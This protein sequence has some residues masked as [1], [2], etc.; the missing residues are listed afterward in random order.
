MQPQPRSRCRPLLGLRKEQVLQEPQAGVLPPQAEVLLRR[1][2][3]PY[4]PLG[5]AAPPPI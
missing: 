2:P 5:A 1:E 3:Q 4:S